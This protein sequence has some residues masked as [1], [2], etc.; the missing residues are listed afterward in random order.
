MNSLPSPARLFPEARRQIR[1]RLVAQLLRGRSQI[2]SMNRNWPDSA[3]GLGEKRRTA[4]GR[5]D[6][7]LVD[8]LLQE[9]KQCLP[10]GVQGSPA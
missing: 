1:N 8:G 2:S 9:R 7:E 6:P 5:G 10:L 3:G 4:S